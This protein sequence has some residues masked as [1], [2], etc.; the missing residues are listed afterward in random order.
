MLSENEPAKSNSYEKCPA[1]YSLYNAQIL[2]ANFSENIQHIVL[3][4]IAITKFLRALLLC[5]VV[6]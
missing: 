4:V 6:C 5:V 3:M 2:K 1:I